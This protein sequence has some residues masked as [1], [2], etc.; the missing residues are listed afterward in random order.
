MGSASLCLL[1]LSRPAMQPVLANT[2]PSKNTSE[3]LHEDLSM[4]KACPRLGVQSPT[5]LGKL[6]HVEQDTT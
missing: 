2:E 6:R 3:T 4:I 1:G 5:D